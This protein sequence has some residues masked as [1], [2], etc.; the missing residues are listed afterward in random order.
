MLVVITGATGFLGSRLVSGMLEN[1]HEVVAL[2]RTSS[3]LWRLGAVEHHPGITFVDVDSVAV[4]SVFERSQVDAVIHVAT[5]YARGPRTVS[6]SSDLIA[7]N[8]TYPMAVLSS[9]IAHG[10]PLFINTDSYFN[11]PGKTYNALQ[12]YSLTK[13]YFLDWLEHHSDAIRVVNMRL[14]HIYGPNDSPDKFVPTLIEQ[15]GR[16]HVE[17][18]AM[19]SGAQARD[20]IHVDDVVAAYLLVLHN[21]E[22]LS[23][24]G[25]DHYE[26]GTGSAIT[27][28]DLALRIKALSGSPTRIEFGRLLQRADEIPLSVADAAFSEDYG[29][30]ESVTLDQGLRS[31]LGGNL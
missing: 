24:P 12:G 3:D 14:E 11:K 7:A 22:A 9:A 28:R 25:Y 2:K 1:G 4:E 21:F 18:F 23:S 8:L 20:F 27:V 30:A 15:I 17:S 19:T 29:F 13:K 10:T 5:N 31:L 26:I 6:T 16:R